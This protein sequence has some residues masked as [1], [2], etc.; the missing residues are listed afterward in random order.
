MVCKRIIIGEQL[1]RQGSIVFLFLC[2]VPKE[3]IMLV[4]NDMSQSLFFDSYDYITIFGRKVINNSDSSI[5]V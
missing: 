1:H 5:L 2:K 3:D 4:R